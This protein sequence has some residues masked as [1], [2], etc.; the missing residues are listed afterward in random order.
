[1]AKAA[2]EADIA[3]TVQYRQGQRERCLAKLQ[4]NPSCSRHDILTVFTTHQL[5][6]NTLDEQFA[7]QELSLNVR[8]IVTAVEAIGQC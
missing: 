4:S 6:T 2:K 5:Y 3:C 7:Q 1:M 8:T